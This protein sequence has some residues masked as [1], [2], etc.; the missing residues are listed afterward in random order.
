MPSTSLSSKLVFNNSYAHLPNVFFSSLSPTA[1]TKPSLIR[2][3]EALATELGIDPNWLASDEALAIL[4]GNRVPEGAEPIAAVYAGHQFGHFNPQLGDGRAI[5]LGEML[6]SEGRRFDI[7]LKG[8]GPTPYS[9]GGDGRSPLGP[10]LREYLISEAMHTL[11]VPTSRALAAVASGDTVMRDSPLPGAIL[12]RVASSHIRIG[13]FEYFAARK[14]YQ[15]LETLTRY[16]LERHYP[17]RLHSDNPALALLEGVIERQAR[18]ISSWQLLGFIHGVMNTDNMLL[19][20]ETIDYGPCAFM[21][22]FNPETVFSSIDHHGRYA[23]HQQPAIA[24]WNLAV[25]AQ[26]LLPLLHDNQ[27]Q[28]VE[29]AQAAVDTFPEHFQAAHL[30]GLQKKLGLSE[31]RPEDQQLVADLFELMSKHGVDFTLFFRHLA[32]LAAP[33]STSSKVSELF[34]LPAS[35]LPWLQRWQARCELDKCGAAE[36]QQS[37]YRANPVYIPRNHLVEELINSATFDNDF[38]P[39]HRLVERLAKPFEFEPQDSRYALPPAANEVVQR[40]FCG[41]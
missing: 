16:T 23:Y 13:S 6:S 26:C 4:A 1:V 27:D 11:G 38:K 14:D 12:T 10:V 29:L 40:T 19:C 24:H 15:A 41:T 17:D 39:F 8:S 9:R 21:D 35:F 22:S 18:L 3:N 25:L 34:T 32:D 7:Q 2:V 31:T 33:Q 36:R 37:M 20:G 28:A 5:L 30:A